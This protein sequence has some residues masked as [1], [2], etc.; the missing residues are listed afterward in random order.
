MSWITSPTGL[1]FTIGGLAALAAFFGGL[2][3]IGPS[4]ADQ[5]AVQTEL[6]RGNGGPTESQRERLAR[7][8]RRMRLATRLDLPLL[9][10]AGLTMAVARYL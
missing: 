1:A 7:A 6:A 2:V 5:T 3:L 10:L 9:S 8:E 4:I